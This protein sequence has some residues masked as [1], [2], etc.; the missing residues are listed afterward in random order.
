MTSNMTS[1]MRESNA[2]YGQPRPFTIL[3]LPPSRMHACPS[4]TYWFCPHTFFC[5]FLSTFSKV[6]AHINVPLHFTETS[7]KIY[8][9]YISVLKRNVAYYG[10]CMGGTFY[11]GTSKKRKNKQLGPTPKRSVHLTR[12]QA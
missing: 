12:F 7:T 9:L 1:N 5:V 4:H 2:E 3:Y 10:E 6:F 11:C 8:E